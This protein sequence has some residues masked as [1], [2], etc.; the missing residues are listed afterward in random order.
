VNGTTGDKPYAIPMTNP[1]RLDSS[2][3]PEIYHYGLRNPWRFSFDRLTGDMWI[4][5]VGQNSWEEMDFAGTC[6]AGLNFGWRCKEGF[7]PYVNDSHCARK[8]SSTPFS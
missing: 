8:T 7:L 4:S 3:L 5:D 6:Q 2:A 1:F